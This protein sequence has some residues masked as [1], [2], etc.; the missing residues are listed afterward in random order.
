MNEETLRAVFDEEKERFS[1]AGLDVESAKLH[2]RTFHSKD[3]RA[4]AKAFED[5]RVFFN[6]DVLPL[7][8][9]CQVRA[10]VRHELS[11]V[12]AWYLTEAECDQLAEE[13]GG[14]KIYYG[15]GDIQTT[16][17]GGIRP[18]PDYLPK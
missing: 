7:L 15:E 17:R 18:R 10:I 4:C 5:G 13:V 1:G 12:A 2:I 9:R 3:H 8:D 16:T 14:K 6:R 11:H